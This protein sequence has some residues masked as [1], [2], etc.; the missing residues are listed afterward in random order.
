MLVCDR[1]ARP[2][3][4]L[5]CA[6]QE[7]DSKHL[8]AVVDKVRVRR[9]GRGRPRRRAR[10]VV[11]DKGFSYPRCRQALRKRGIK[12][13]IPERSDQKK[14]RQAKGTRGGRPHAFDH[15]LYKERSL[16]E[17]CFLRLK[18]FR[19]LAT[20]YDKRAQVYQTFLTL[21]TILIWIRS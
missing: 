12:A 6:G 3:A 4:T 18:Q 20:R 17:R 1:K 10:T 15:A 8:E 14:Q 5:V 21:A 2:M 9:K 13:M 19:R 16:V 7:H 11:G